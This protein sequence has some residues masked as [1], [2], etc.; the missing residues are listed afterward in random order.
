MVY[1]FA[2]KNRKKPSWLMLQHCIKR[3]FGGFEHSHEQDP[4]T[5]FSRNLK[6]VEKIIKV[7]CLIHKFSLKKLQTK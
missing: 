2:E 3:N 4:V 7:S 1:S 5:V 6:T